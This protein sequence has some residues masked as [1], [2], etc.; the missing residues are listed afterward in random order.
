MGVDSG[1][2]YRQTHSL[3]HLAW[4]WVGG[5]LAPFYI[6][7][8]NRV[9]SRNGSAMMTAPYTLSW[10]LLY[11]Y[12]IIN[13]FVKRRKQSYR[14]IIILIF[15]GL[16]CA[17]LGFGYLTFQ[18]FNPSVQKFSAVFLS[19]KSDWWWLFWIVRLLACERISCFQ[20]CIEHTHKVYLTL[21]KICWVMFFF[22]VGLLEISRWWIRC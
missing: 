15:C 8:M 20:W 4:S 2:H 22:V 11:S 10:I 7:Q 12:H 3:S 1:S 21:L 6:H 13:I 5:R 19:V 9:N 18:N 16:F 14:A 17:Y